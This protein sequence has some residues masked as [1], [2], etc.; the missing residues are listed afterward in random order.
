M[1]ILSIQVGA[2]PDEDTGDGV[3]ARGGA[4]A[5]DRAHDRPARIQQ[6]G[7]QEARLRLPLRRLRGGR[8][9][10]QNMF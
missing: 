5:A 7:G 10:K 1:N 9:G 6:R 4:R 2:L 3:V 8:G